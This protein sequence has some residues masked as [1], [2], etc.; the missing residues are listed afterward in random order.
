MPALSSRLRSIRRLIAVAAVSYGLYYV[1]A[2]Q[3]QQ[4]YLPNPTPRDPDLHDK[5]KED[6]LEKV[7][8]QQAA[9]LRKAQVR[10]QVAAATDRLVRLAQQLK[11]EMEKGDKGSPLSV[12]A[13]KAAE[14]EKLAKTVKNSMKS[15]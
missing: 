12:S 2:A 10:Q 7:R 14:I 9:Q 15:Q 6:P 1:A 13:Q 11:D 5:Y 3:N 4:I 8:Q